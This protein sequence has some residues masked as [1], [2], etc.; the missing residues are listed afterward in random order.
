[1]NL[2]FTFIGIIIG[3]TVFHVAG[4]VFGGIIG[5]LA[6]GLHDLQSRQEKQ[7]QDL[8]WLRKRLSEHLRDDIRENSGAG[9]SIFGGSVYPP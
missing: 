2:L 1:M 4:A 6:G 7:Q 9:I 5:W 3:G 8:S